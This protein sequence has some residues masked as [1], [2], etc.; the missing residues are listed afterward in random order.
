MN[1]GEHHP[2]AKWFVGF[3]GGGGDLPR[4]YVVDWLS[5][6]GFWH[7]MAFAYDV[8]GER[9]LLYDVNRGGVTILSLPPAQFDQWLTHMRHVSGM[10]VLQVEVRPAPRFWLQI[11]LW[12]TVAVIHLVG[13]KS[14]ALRPIG[15]WRDLCRGGAR[16][17]FANA[18]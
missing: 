6:R 9:W 17:A 16:E 5:P 1:D 11:G 3:L 14:A 12:C 8:G 2:I 10:R 15:L 7:C 18:A 13:A 4:R